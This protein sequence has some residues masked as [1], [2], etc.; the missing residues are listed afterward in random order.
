MA[1]NQTLLDRYQRAIDVTP[2]KDCRKLESMISD[3]SVVVATKNLVSC[4][5]AGEEVI[6]DLDTG[7]YFGLNPVGTRIW[8]LIQEPRTI[9]DVRDIL[10][11]EYEVD[12]DQCQQELL[13]LLQDMAQQK[14]IEVRNG[15]SR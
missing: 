3:H 2:G 10:L 15:A 12:A 4:D 13:A 8:S 1:I 9:S 5:L 6:L 14:L 11:A 7:I